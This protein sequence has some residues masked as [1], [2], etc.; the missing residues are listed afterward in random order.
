MAI[1]I[2][3]VTRT[4]LSTA[5]AEVAND[6]NGN[7]HLVSYQ[8]RGAGLTR[9]ARHSFLFHPVTQTLPRLPV[10]RLIS[11]TTNYQSSRV[12]TT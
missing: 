5:E 3:V 10:T 9:D 7:Y 8:N 12:D 6:L 1:D 4:Q 2:L 11:M